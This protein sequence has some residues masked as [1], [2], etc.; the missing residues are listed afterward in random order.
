MLNHL[1]KRNEQSDKNPQHKYLKKE[2]LIELE[3]K[4][5]QLEKQKSNIQ[6]VQK[7]NIIT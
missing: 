2:H 6:K 5:I 7:N 1:I 4:L 3:E